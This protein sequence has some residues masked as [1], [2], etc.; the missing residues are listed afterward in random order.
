MIEIQDLLD[1]SYNV[2]WSVS[3]GPGQLWER[4]HTYRLDDLSKIGAEQ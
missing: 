4:V 2:M 3:Q 1:G